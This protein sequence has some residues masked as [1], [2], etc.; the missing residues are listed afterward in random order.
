M[1]KDYN[2]FY[3]NRCGST[4]IDKWAKVFGLRLSAIVPLTEW[5]NFEIEL[6]S[7]QSNDIS[8]IPSIK[9][10]IV[11]ISTHTYSGGVFTKRDTPVI[12][13]TD[14]S[15]Y[16]LE[17][18]N[19]CC[20]YD[21]NYINFY[22]KCNNSNEFISGILKHSLSANLF[23]YFNYE[24]FETDISS[25]TPNSVFV[26]S[27]P[28]QKIP[29]AKNDGSATPVTI[30]GGSTWTKVNE[31]HVW[32]VALYDCV[33]A[34]TTTIVITND[35][36][37]NECD[38]FLDIYNRDTGSSTNE[39][40]RY[41]GRTSYAGTSTVTTVIN[42]AFKKGDIIKYDL[43]ARCSNTNAVASVNRYRMSAFIIPGDLA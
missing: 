12:A 38:V 27:T 41:M 4:E 26:S 28:C 43:F 1:A 14:H 35:T 18:I 16:E 29:R 8:S 40:Y 10:Y 7:K 24:N 33:V 11:T 25:S 39:A 17:N 19:V 32:G 23:T 6:C 31:G 22:V 37:G 9:K 3:T 34:V 30:T 2:V 13:I 42:K 15:Y 20:I 5:L 36:D 21:D